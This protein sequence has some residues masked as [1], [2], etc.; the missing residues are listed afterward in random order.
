MILLIHKAF[1]TIKKLHNGKEI[2]V[3]E[4][5]LTRT[6]E[7]RTESLAT[8]WKNAEMHKKLFESI[9]LSPQRTNTQKC[10]W[11]IQFISNYHYSFDAFFCKNSE[12]GWVWSY[13]FY[14]KMIN[15]KISMASKSK[16]IKGSV[17]FSTCTLFTLVKILYMH[18]YVKKGDWLFSD[19]LSA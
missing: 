13:F 10:A 1:I 19:I 17:F 11:T 7:L 18:P 16:F 9:L 5:F 4:F 3:K 8:R 15:D 14:T 12:I 6:S 2:K